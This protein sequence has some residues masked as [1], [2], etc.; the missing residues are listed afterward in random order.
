MIALNFVLALFLTL[1]QPAATPKPDAF[2][3][4]SSYKDAALAKLPKGYTFLKSFGINGI[5]KP[6]VEYSYIFSRN[7]A[8]IITLDNGGT[9]GMI[10]EL[11]D[12]NKKFVAT[13]YAKGKFYQALIYECKATGIYYMKFYFKDTNR[14]CA[15]GVLGFSRS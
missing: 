4:T 1:G 11:Y 15:A 3:D 12:S 14:R 6:T 7:S 2:C 9:D 10:V 5:Q 8:Y 13:S